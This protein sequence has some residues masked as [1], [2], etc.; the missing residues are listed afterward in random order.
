MEKQ[1][2]KTTSKRN[3]YLK[4][5]LICAVS[6]IILSLILSYFSSAFL[7]NYINYAWT[8]FLFRIRRDHYAQTKN[9][10]R[11]DILIIKFDDYS[12]KRLNMFWP[13]K[14][15]EMAKVVNFLR[16]SGA[17]TILYDI[18]FA[19]K[20]PDDPEGDKSLEE[21]IKKSK[22]SYMGT[23]YY[24]VIEQESGLNLDKEYETSKKFAVNFKSDTDKP[25]NYQ[26]FILVKNGQIHHPPFNEILENAKGIG[27]FNTSNKSKDVL[28]TALTVNCDE[29]NLCFASLP[30]SYYLDVQGTKDIKIK[31][32]DYLKI[33]T[34]RI[35]VNE[36]NEYYINW[37]GGESDFVDVALQAE[38]KAQLEAKLKELQKEPEKNADQINDLSK[39]IK[40]LNRKNMFYEGVSVYNLIL[41]M[42]SLI[43]VAE[44][45][46]KTPDEIYNW[47]YNSSDLDDEVEVIIDPDKF[48]D[49]I[50]VLGVSSSGAQDH[51]YTPFGRMPGVFKHAIILDNLLSYNFLKAPHKAVNY[52]ILIFLCLLTAL[53]VIFSSARNNTILL[54]T[55]FLLMVFI[56]LLWLHLFGAYNILLDWSSPMM[57]VLCTFFISMLYYFFVEGKDKQQIKKAMANYISPQ[58]MKMVTENPELLSPDNTQRKNISIF[59]FDIRS[60]TTISE[61]SQPE[62]IAKMLNEYHSEI[63]GII[64]NNKGTLDK[65]IGDAV[66]AFWNAPVDIED[67]SYMAVKS[68]L[69]V[70][71]RLQYLNKRWAEIVNHKVDFGIGINTADVVVGNIGSDKFMDY[72]IIGDGVNLASRLEGLNKQFGTN[73]IISEFTYALL[74]DK[75]KVRLLGDVKVKGK[76]EATQIYEL[77]SLK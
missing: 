70:K 48:K 33:G 60:F 34:T 45:Y 17:K 4:M 41:S 58:V 57:S 40:T 26:D 18:L 28:R 16:L 43:K 55:P 65:I 14:R 19:Y 52:I 36:N 11:D 75:I 24:E 49:K 67:H 5:F 44:K 56:S 21:A 64:F 62:M 61:M 37:Y 25:I 73:I 69:E 6:G 7:K 13:Y 47:W 53:I 8:D 29:K 35:P 66:M 12:N 71:E 42:N 23:K 32:Q 74:R 68:A 9:V 27:F 77:L 46:N 76:T 59:F 1:N 50:V 63:I 3:K 2:K 72:T 15:Q 31:D 38:K 10:P 22:M 39:E 54:F 51:I 30:I 20:S